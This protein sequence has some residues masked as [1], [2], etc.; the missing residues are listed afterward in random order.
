LAW[1]HSG[2]QALPPKR[3]SLLS[4]EASARHELSFQRP[5]FPSQ[6]VCV[7]LLLSWL[8]WS[9]CG[10]EVAAEVWSM[11]GR[12]RDHAD[13]GG[14]VRLLDRRLAQVGLMLQIHGSDPGTRVVIEAGGVILLIDA[15][16]DGT[17]GSERVDGAAGKGS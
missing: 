12:C 6:A 15:A 14:N 11:R 5:T 10:T 2:G 13:C 7:Y 16:S 4:P 1:S 3:G 17:G 8:G 9:S